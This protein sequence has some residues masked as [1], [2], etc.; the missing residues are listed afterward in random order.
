MLGPEDLSFHDMANIMTDVLGKPIRFHSVP[1]GEYKVQLLRFGASEE[2][3]QGRMDMYT[4]IDQ[5]LCSQ[6]REL[7]K[8]RL[9][10]ISGN[11]VRKS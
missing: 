1:A 3:A 8:T 7:R 4:A 2:M 11:G 6:N 9:R 10:S 5:G